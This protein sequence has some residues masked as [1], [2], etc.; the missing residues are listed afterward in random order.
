MTRDR[1]GIL[2][3][4]LQL[5]RRAATLPIRA[6]Q[7]FVSPF[8]PATCR[9]RPTCSA[10]AVEA[11]ESHGIWRGGWMALRR[12]LRCHPFSEPGPDPVPPPRNDHRPPHR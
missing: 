2:D 8:T 1:P 5:V 12:I 11:V 3:R 9:F 4:L 10:Y 7:R 6:Y